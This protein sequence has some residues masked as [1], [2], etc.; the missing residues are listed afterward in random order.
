MSGVAASM[1]H[2]VLAT[3][4]VRKVIGLPQVTAMGKRVAPRTDLALQRL[5]RGKVS[6][7]N[8]CGAPSLVLHTVGR[9][10]GLPRTT[11][12]MC[13][14][15]DGGFYVVGSNWGQP[16][17]PGWALNL[18]ADPQASIEDRGR[19][20]PVTARLLEGA[21]RAEAW[22]VMAGI[23]PPFDDYVE[24]SGGREPMVFLLRTSD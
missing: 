19:R 10:T 2:K 16:G 11:P 7:V 17:H 20:R 18:R 4:P 8:L 13:G 22:R 5:T 9:K 24:R 21:E 23:W 3:K 6:L 14:R 15:A 1:R 12:L